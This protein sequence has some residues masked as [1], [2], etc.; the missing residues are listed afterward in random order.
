MIWTERK[1]KQ[2]RNVTQTED[3]PWMHVTIKQNLLEV[4][5]LEYIETELN[6]I[7]IRDKFN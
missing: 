6:K 1:K 3:E 2:T 7:T 5:T 4:V